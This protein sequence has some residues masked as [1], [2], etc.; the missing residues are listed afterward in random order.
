MDGRSTAPLPE[1][2]RKRL[3]QK[4]SVLHVIGPQS[5]IEIKAHSLPKSL[6]H[7]LSGLL[8]LL[9]LLANLATFLLS[10]S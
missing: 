1:C 7:L 9:L 5:P 6:L 2:P 10:M 3:G 4:V 8:L